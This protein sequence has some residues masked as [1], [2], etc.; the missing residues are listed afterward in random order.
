MKVLI[1]T[2][3]LP[4]SDDDQVPAFVKDQAIELKKKYPTIE[5][6][7]HAPHN[8]YSQT[9]RKQLADKYYTERRFHYFWPFRMELLAGRGIL[10]ALR[11][12][13]LL[14]M[15]IPFFVFFQFL[16]LLVLVRKEKPDLIYAH[17]FTPQAIN[18]ALVS[19]I[20]K[21]PF[22][23]TTHASDVSVIRGVPLSKTIVTL[24]CRSAAAYTAV[25]KRTA[26]KL[27]S[28]FDTKKPLYNKLSIIP[29]GVKTNALKVSKSDL[30]NVRESFDIAQ[31]KQYILF[32]GRLAEKKG[33]IYLLQAF[34]QLPAKYS[35]DL[36]L[37]VAGD[38]QLK[39]FLEKRAV[40]LGITNITF[41]GYV[42]GKTKDSLLELAD[43]V[44]FP[45]IIDDRGDS[46]GFPVALM[47]S[48]AAG[49]IVLASNATGGETILQDGVSGFIF[50]EKSAKSLV[51]SLVQALKLSKRA[52]MEMQKSSRDLS[53]Q[54]DW[55][56]ITEKHYDI[57][58]KVLHENTS[59]K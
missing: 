23:F 45:S 40:D 7:I 32:L 13:K 59:H 52:R 57:L 24:V 34:A 11:Q 17:W 3:T 48:L 35:K 18:A 50:S 58:K 47:E 42:H 21:T 8:T 5:I 54:F 20:T 22:I 28:F 2:S 31:D 4:V 46:E 29:M 30:A 36:H 19:R 38:G 6:V 37:I 25:S 44:C 16:T 12:N 9:S 51:L 10:P 56:T 14:Y 43:Y 15:Q 33:V 49:K 26:D 55:S 53:M 41:T 27:T 1:T 39:P